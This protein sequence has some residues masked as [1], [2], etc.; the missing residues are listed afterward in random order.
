MTDTP[1]SAATLLSD[2]T[3]GFAL[4]TCPD[5]AIAAA[6]NCMVDAVGCMVGGVAMSSSQMALDMFV[7][8][9]NGGLVTV[10]GSAQRLGLLDAAWLGGHSANALDFDDCFRDGAPSHPGA[11]VIPPAFALAE[12]RGLHGADFLASIIAGYEVS[13]RIGRAMNA[14]PERNAE[15]MGYAP[16]QTF[17]AAVAGAHL[18]R[19]DPQRIR[20]AFGIAALQAPVPSVRKAVEGLRPYGWLKNSYGICCQSGLQ[21][22][23][24]AEKGFHGH[25]EIFDGPYG[26]W[27]MAGSDRY[28]P[29]GFDALGQDWMITRTEFKPYAACR[30][31]HTT[32]EG[33]AELT[34]GIGPERIARIELHGFG[35]FYVALG[36]DLPSSIVDAQFNARYL[37]ALEILG[38]SPANGLSEADLTD[39]TVREMASRITL[40]HAPEYD[41]L[42]HRSM[43]TPVRIIVHLTNGETRET[44]IEEPP[45]SIKRGGFQRRQICE[46]FLRLCAPV[47]GDQPAEEALRCLLDIANRPVAELACLLTPPV[48]S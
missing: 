28:D 34:A 8:A 29:A 48:G 30:W 41:A 25:Q 17:G 31:S 20:S 10:P 27:I 16:W 14:S 47:L 36:G 21:A 19:L 3:A 43:S 40:H 23:L 11:T 13:L 39:P 32:I 7:E 44:Y 38:R 1:F 5:T 2:W 26:F 46:K 12:A 4:D 18:L 45:T 37:G 9:G 22:A 33:L 24:L 42:H 35:E 15:V 6:L